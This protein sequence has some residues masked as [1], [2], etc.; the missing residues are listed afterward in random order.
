MQFLFATGVGIGVIVLTA[1][2]LLSLWLVVY[3]VIPWADAAL[4]RSI[5][6]DAEDEHA[7]DWGRRS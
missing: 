3:R 4:T 7:S 2:T 6:G 5:F 1:A